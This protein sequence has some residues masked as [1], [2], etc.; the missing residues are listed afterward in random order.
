MG[1]A[2]GQGAQG[3]LQGHQEET[4]ALRSAACQAPNAATNHSE[5]ESS[6][7]PSPAPDDTAVPPDTLTAAL[8][9]TD[10]EPGQLHPES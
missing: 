1:W 10:T 5:L 6:F 7:F 9:D 4:E 2:T 8:L 3:C